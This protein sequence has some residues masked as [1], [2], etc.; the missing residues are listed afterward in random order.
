MVD[1][2]SFARSDGVDLVMDRAAGE[3]DSADVWLGLV[4]MAVG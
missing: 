4:V 3:E 1:T 2:S